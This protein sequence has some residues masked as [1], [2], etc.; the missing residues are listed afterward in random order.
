MNRPAA[1][2]RP[3]EVKAT[4]AA[5]VSGAFAPL[6]T[7]RSPLRLLSYAGPVSNDPV[8]IGF[9]QSIGANEPLL[10]GRLRE[11]AGVHPL[12][13]HAVAQSAAVGV[14]P[15]RGSPPSNESGRPGAVRTRVFRR[16]T[17]HHRPTVSSTPQPTVPRN[18]VPAARTAA[19]KGDRAALFRAR[20]R[21]G[22][23][24]PKSPGTAALSGIRPDRQVD[25]RGPR[26]PT[27]G[28]VPSISFAVVSRRARA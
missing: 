24:P 13:Q 17:G 7:D 12:H 3:L 26:T 1:L 2:D 21:G 6:R 11:D 23:R 14:P 4:N 15:H 28:A 8:T 19:V 10:T 27:I 20:S 9:R 18:R 25:C 16:C 22:R 5:D